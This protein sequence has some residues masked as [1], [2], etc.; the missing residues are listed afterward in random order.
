MTHHNIDLWRG[1]APVDAA[2]YGMWP[3]GGAWLCQHLWEHYAFTGDK[4]F[5]KEYYPV[6]KGAAQF[7]LELM[8][9]G[10]EAPLAGHA[11]LHVARSTDTTTP[12]GKWRSSR[13]RRPWT[14]PSSASLFPHC[15]EASKILGVD[16]DFRGKL[17]AALTRLPPYRINRLGYLQEWIEDWKAGPPGTQR[18]AQLHV[19]SRQFHHAARRPGTGRRDPEMDGDPPAP[20]RLALRL[21]HQRVGPPGARRQGR[22]NGVHALVANSLAPNLHNSGSNQ[23]DASFGFTAAVAE[24]LLQS[25]AGEIS[26]LPALPDGW[27]DGSV[28]GL[29]ARG[30]FEVDIRWK[31]GKLQSAEIRSSERRPATCDT[32]R[33]P[34]RFRS[35][36][37]IACD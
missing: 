15:I 23:S 20:R 1:T 22:R 7:L 35:S 17:E 29:R 13:R 24:A 8:V 21:G 32:K 9:G 27:P 10:A 18:L 11:V 16:E 25:H 5:L 37:A 14:S 33:G 36:P 28:R 6:M 34:P 19:L 30:G 12:T 26:L 2:R 4:Q 3:V 31:G